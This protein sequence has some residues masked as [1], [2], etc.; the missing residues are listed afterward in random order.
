MSQWHTIEVPN[1][2]YNIYG[3]YCLPK[4]TKQ[5]LSN[6]QDV[7]ES[8]MRATVDANKI[9]KEYIAERIKHFVKD[10]NV[11]GIYRLAMKKDADNIRSSSVQGVVKRIREKLQNKII[12]YEPL[13]KDRTLF[14]DNEVVN[15][16]NSFKERS[17]II[18]A[19]R[20]DKML[21]D[22]RG[23]VFTR[24]LFGRD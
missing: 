12:I 14:Y 2:I 1:R 6:Y 11:I 19:N 20:Y 23:K 17:D 15:D 24:D 5:L 3:G 16:L 22:V 8:I 4:D 7:P 18:L 9:R 21:D 13:L 10:E